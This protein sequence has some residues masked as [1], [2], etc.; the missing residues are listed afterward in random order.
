[1]SPHQDPWGRLQEEAREALISLRNTRSN[2][3]VAEKYDPKWEGVADL[4]KPR[5][6]ALA[7]AL[8]AV[9]LLDV[10]ADTEPAATLAVQQ[11]ATHHSAGERDANGCGITEACDVT[12]VLLSDGS[13]WRMWGHAPDALWIRLPALHTA[14]GGGDA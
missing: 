5:I 7:D 13:I 6:D 12:T 10:P 1:M 2:I 3:M 11:I 8:N 4:L 14:S 9:S